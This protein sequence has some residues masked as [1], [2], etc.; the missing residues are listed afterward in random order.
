MNPV[1]ATAINMLPLPNSTLGASDPCTIASPWTATFS[2][3]YTDPLSENTLA[4]K[5]DYHISD[6]DSLSMRY[7]R[8]ASNTQYRGS[9]AQ[10]DIRVDP[11]TSKFGKI[12]YLHTFSPH[13]LNE[14][15]IGI[16]RTEAIPISSDQAAVRNFPWS[17]I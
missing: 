8:N 10:G 4:G 6:K 14:V 13:L 16:N 11:Y 5:L 17:M 9:I 7:N 3:S 15:G 1:L 2:S 12:T